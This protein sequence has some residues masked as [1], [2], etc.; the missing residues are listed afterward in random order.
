MITHCGKFEYDD[1]GGGDGDGGGGGGGT[2][3][4]VGQEKGVRGGLEFL[5][6]T[7]KKGL[8]KR[9]LRCEVGEAA[10]RLIADICTATGKFH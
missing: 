2:W 4:G 10:A 3:E 9:L 1:R 5:N 8:F 7:R 6:L